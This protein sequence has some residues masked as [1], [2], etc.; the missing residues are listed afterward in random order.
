MVQ[1]IVTF[2]DYVSLQLLCNYFKNQVC[3][4]WNLRRQSPCVKKLENCFESVSVVEVAAAIFFAGVVAVHVPCL[5][6]VFQGPLG[7][8]EALRDGPLSNCGVAPA[9]RCASS[10]V[11]QDIF[12]NQNLNGTIFFLKILVTSENATKTVVVVTTPFVMRQTLFILFRRAIFC[13]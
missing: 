11:V 7:T 8:V 13:F 9:C 6:P 5:F 2:C 4:S 3:F 10:Y 1:N 12:H